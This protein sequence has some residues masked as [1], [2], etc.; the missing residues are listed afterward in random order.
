MLLFSVARLGEL[1]T[2]L[3]NIR[4]QVHSGI[5]Y[6]LP[7]GAGWRKFDVTLDET[8]LNRLHPH[9]DLSVHEAFK[10][11]QRNADLLCAAKVAKETS[12]DTLVVRTLLNA[13]SE[14]KGINYE[15]NP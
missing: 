9:G 3:R 12:K 2:S 10:L 6:E 8:D 15:P 5:T 4:V 7:D 11:L 14:P 13:A 1:G